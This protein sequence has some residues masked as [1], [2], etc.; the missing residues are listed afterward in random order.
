V[1]ALN[2]ALLNNKHKHYSNTEVQNLAM[3][4]GQ[5]IKEM[6][7]AKKISGKKMAAYCEITPGGVSSWFATGRISKQK[8]AL[9]A[10]LLQVS[11]D[12]LISGYAPIST[13]VPIDHENNLAQPSVAQAL[14]AMVSQLTPLDAGTRETIANLAHEALC[15]PEKTAANMAAINALM[16]FATGKVETA[17]FS[18]TS[19][20]T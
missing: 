4:I 11:T 12:E 1:H 19:K 8:L 6:M 2:I 7:D 10:E 3:H 13:P 14:E 18:Q 9:A 5:R 16:R 17:A 20:A 15:K